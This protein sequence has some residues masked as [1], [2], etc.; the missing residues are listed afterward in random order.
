[1][2]RAAVMTSLSFFLSTDL[3][4]AFHPC[5]VLRFG[6]ANGKGVGN[7]EVSPISIGLTS[8]STTMKRKVSI[9]GRT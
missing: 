5:R 9:G 6:W 7:A 2:N 4:N 1:M 3:S 8:P